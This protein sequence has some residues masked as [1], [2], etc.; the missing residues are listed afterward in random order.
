MIKPV[1]IA[2]I[3]AA[4]YLAAG[5]S[6][7]AQST[8]PLLI[9]TGTGAGLVANPKFWTANSGT[10]ADKFAAGNDSRILAGSSAAA[11]FLGSGTITANSSGTLGSAAFT[12]SGAYA[13]AAQGA[14]AD[15]ALQSAHVNSATFSVSGSSATSRTL[16]SKLSDT[17]SV[18]DFGATGD[19]VTD[20]TT[21]IQSAMNT[22]R[23]VFF[24][25]GTYSISD[26]IYYKGAGQIIT[27]DG[28][29]T[30]SIRQTDA[31]DDAVK[32][33][34]PSI[35]D[36]VDQGNRLVFS[37]RIENIAIRG[38]GKASSTGAG[39]RASGTNSSF[40]GDWLQVSNVTIRGFDKGIAVQG[41]GQIRVEQTLC[42]Y[43]NTGMLIEGGSVNSYRIA[44]LACVQGT[45]GLDIQSG[46]GCT[47]ELGD[48]G[49][50]STVD[51]NVAVGG[52]TFI[53]GNFESSPRCFD[54]AAS[55]GATIIG[56]RFLRTSS[57]TPPI[58]VAGTGGVF[59]QASGQAG[60]VAGTALVEKSASTA[61]AAGFTTPATSN[62]GSTDNSAY[63]FTDNGQTFRVVPWAARYFNS[64]PS[65]SSGLRGQVLQVI[66]PGFSDYVGQYLLDQN[67]TAILDEWSNYRLRV[68]SATGSASVSASSNTIYRATGGSL[69]TFT[70]P[71]AG[72][73]DDVIQVIGVGAGGW[74]ITQN[75]SQTIRIGPSVTT[76]GTGGFLQSTNQYD[77][78]TLKCTT[79]TTGWRV[80]DYTGSPVTD[81]GTGPV[82]S[83]T[84]AAPSNTSTPAGWSDVT[85]SG[86]TFKVP[87]YQ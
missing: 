28:P 6:L 83:G 67:G 79:G 2:I 10:G 76:S 80:I 8:G 49:N 3:A 61:I 45:T 58:R 60:Q 55:A 14:T 29:W 31:A 33:Y 15:T 51:V 87:L 7:F 62:L 22:K 85:V 54:I 24:P 70:L 64:I 9:Q 39:F 74:K 18:K 50:N 59:L 44:G 69:Q 26:P 47:Y 75:A 63:S 13:T 53:G 12:D 25:T 73:V 20:D 52:G 16:Q 11:R 35:D 32:A 40:N 19:G 27:G 56:A 38:V 57:T 34:A 84:N 68:T 36:T 37:Q 66:G 17:I 81:A 78:V 1:I 46:S 43:N 41:I 65:A 23:S 77:T 21:A 82:F 72:Q 5:I 42:T 4:A 48:F 30:T 71:A 86:T